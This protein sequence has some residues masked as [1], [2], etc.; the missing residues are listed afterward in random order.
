MALVTVGVQSPSVD[1]ANGDEQLRLPPLI[2]GL[3]PELPVMCKRHNVQASQGSRVE[4]ASAIE[5]GVECGEGGGLAG[6]GAG[7]GQGRVRLNLDPH[8]MVS[9]FRDDCTVETLRTLLSC[10]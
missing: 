1:G 7:E 3:A 2:V 10:W 8:S 6:A 5:G 4:A 9:L